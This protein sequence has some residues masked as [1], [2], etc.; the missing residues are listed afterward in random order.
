[1]RQHDVIGCAPA[2][3]GAFQQRGVEPAAMLV[4]SFQIHHGIGAAI[5]LA[6]DMAELRKI[7]AV[8]QHEGV[9]R[10]GVEPD[11]ED[12][13]DLPPVFRGQLFPQEALARAVRIPSVGAFLHEGFD[14]ALVDGLVLQDVDRTVALLFREHGNGNS[15]GALARDHPV[16]L[17]VDHAVDAVLARRRHPACRRDRTQRTCPQRIAGFGLA[18]VL[19]RLV[20]RDEPLRRVAEDHRL[21]RAPGMRILVFE[22]AARQQHAGLDQRLDHGVVGVA[23]F[24]L[25][26]DDAFTRK[27]RRLIGERA[28]FIDGVGNRGVDA[29]RLQFARIRGPDIEVLAAVAGRGVD[30]TGAGV[31]GDVIAFEQRDAEFVTAAAKPLEDARTSSPAKALAEHFRDLLMAGDPCLLLKVIFG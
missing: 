10:P 18:V 25:V 21:L 11:V 23:L 7:L 6:D 5:D 9:G 13:V 24:A 16:R 28:I 26:V 12:V 14:D 22:P 19:D 1:M 15:P 8:F 17:G 3:A 31:V 30:K 29:T 27:T 4:A 2:R 20:H